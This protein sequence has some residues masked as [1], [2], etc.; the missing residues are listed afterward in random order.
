L[1][2][3]AQLGVGAGIAATQP[4][5]L[6]GWLGVPLVMAATV[7]LINGFNLLDGLDMLAAGV[8]LAGFGGRSPGMRCAGRRVSMAMAAS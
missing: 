3:L 5:H 1:R 4:V 6:P 2:L 8:G 7:V